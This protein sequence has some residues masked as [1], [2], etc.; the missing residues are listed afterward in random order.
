MWVAG[1][2]FPENSLLTFLGNLWRTSLR[3]HVKSCQDGVEGFQDSSLSE[4]ELRMH[5]EEK[6]MHK[7]NNRRC[8]NF[9]SFLS[10]FTRELP[11]RNQ[12]HTIWS[13]VDIGWKEEPV[14]LRPHAK[15]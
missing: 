10:N 8:A 12:F 11:W 3:K 1:N 6:R 15:K 14:T 13:L 5:G 9:H 7:Y 4:Q 2:P